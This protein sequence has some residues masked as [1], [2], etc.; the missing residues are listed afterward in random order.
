[1]RVIFH[2]DNTFEVTLPNSLRAVI[3]SNHEEFKDSMGFFLASVVILFIYLL[4][5]EMKLSCLI[6]CVVV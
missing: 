1:M 6:L 5:P 2:L 4:M 3:F